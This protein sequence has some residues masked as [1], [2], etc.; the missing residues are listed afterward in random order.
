MWN[1]KPEVA[2]A[3]MA[4]LGSNVQK[5]KIIIELPKLKE[6]NASKPVDKNA[7]DAAQ[8]KRDRKNAKRRAEFT[9]A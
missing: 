7:S 1:T 2:M 3:I 5:D 8:Q 4:A 6:A 9:A